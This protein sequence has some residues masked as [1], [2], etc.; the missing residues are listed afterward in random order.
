MIVRCAIFSSA[1]LALTL[2][3]IAAQ[4]APREVS[5]TGAGLSDSAQL[6]RGSGWLLIAVVLGLAIFGIMELTG[7]DEP[8]SP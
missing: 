7:D 8:T 4:A 6:G 3:P 1:A 5:R 2:A